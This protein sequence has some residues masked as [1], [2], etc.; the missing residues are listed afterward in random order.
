MKKLMLRWNV[1][2]PRDLIIIF[3]V[4]S[5]TGSSS[6]LIGRPILK[7]LGITLEYIHPIIYYPLFIISSFI[8]YQIFLVIYGWV[9]GQFNFFWNMEKKMLKRFGITI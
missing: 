4:F 1:D 2:T 9:F 8:F 6:V 3:F 7:F 5:I